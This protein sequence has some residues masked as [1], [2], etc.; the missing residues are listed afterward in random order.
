[1]ANK[2]YPKL[3]EKGQIG[4]VAIKNRI[5]R[6]SMGTYLGNPDGTVTD[7]QIK[8][9]AQAAEG[10]AGL[11]FMDNAVPVPMT[12]CG[13]RADKDEFIAGLT[14]LADAL[15]QH[16]AVAGIQLAHPGRDAAF[17]GSADVIGASAITFEP[18]YEMGFKMP[19]A[20]SIEEIHELIERFGDAALRCKKAGFQ[21]LGIH[22]AAGCIPTNFLS[23]HDNKRTDIYGG[24]L[25]NRMRLLVEIIRNIKAKCGRDFPVG[26]KLSTEDWEPEGIRIDET[27]EVAKALEKEG[28]SHLNIMGGTHATACMEFLLPNA[29][30]AEHTRRI[31]EAVHIP[32][33]IGH[34]IFTPE[35]AE[36]MLE[37][38]NGDFVA[39]GRSQLA[40]PEWARKARLG[41]ANHIKPCINCMI[42]CIDKGMLGHTPIR[43]TV[44]PTLY[45]F[46]CEPLT[47]APVAKNVAVVGGGPAGCEAALTASR[48]GHQVTLYEK[49]QF[50]GAM[51]EA[52]KPENKANIR[53]LIHYYEEHIASDPNITIVKAEAD[54]DTLVSGHFDAVIIA[55]GGKPRMLSVPGIESDCVTYACD[56]LNGDR[57][58]SG[59]KVVVIG[60]GITGA[61]TALELYKEGKDVSVVEMTDAFLANPSS[62]CQA[63]NI[64]I[65]KTN[66]QILTGKRL[67][68]VGNG[69]ICL[70]DRWGN[71]ITMP[72]DSVVIAAGFV[73]QYDLSERLEANTD[74]EVFHVGDSARVR[75]IYDAIH[76]GFFAA[77]QI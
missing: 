4:N 46:E 25:H 38:G 76:E 20:L 13:L 57:M 42:G 53:R 7:R 10:G 60:G 56:Y 33:F 3:F 52:G 54:Y 21:I 39:L 77:R 64:E 26:V 45:K 74:L 67:S 68:S 59:Q 8:A 29:F 66:I 41:N 18:W 55:N 75:Q 58:V 65:S 48:R 12:S 40:D 16:G 15:K 72:A 61:E 34:N 19:R 63:Y 49:R 2:Y 1:M 6:N 70:V 22:G 50:G 23:P 14:L 24:S 27:V 44:N 43:C 37:A 51:I 31:K 69:T 36:A 5:V 32:V 71:E 28:V 62:A 17:V 73:P 47:K 35:E 9:Y 11:I 30:N